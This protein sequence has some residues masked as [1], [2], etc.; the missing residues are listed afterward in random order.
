[1]WY[2]PLIESGRVPDAVLRLGIRRLLA[3]RLESERRGDVEVQC[4]SLLGFV[5]K[6]RASPVAVNTREANSQHYEVP[7][8]FFQAVLGPRLK[9]SS[10]LWSEG[11]RD[12]AA[13]ELAMLE[14]TARRAELADGQRILELGCGWGSLTLWMAERFPGARITAVSNSAP[15][16]EFLEARLAEKKLGNVRVI[17]RDMNDFEPEGT[18]DRVVSVEMFEHMKNY[19]E[20][21]ARIARWL[22][23]SGRLFVHIFTHREFA[24]PFEAD[25]EDDWM[26]REFFTGGNMPSDDLLLYFQRDLSIVRH[27]RVNGTHYAR[28]AESWLSNLDQRRG[29][30]RAIF[31]RVYGEARAEAWIE[32]WRIFFMA[33]AELWGYRGGQEWMVSHYLFAP[34]APAGGAR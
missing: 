1:M 23:P 34:R 8:E 28:T 33:C 24:Y 19:E 10:G 31:E 12:L 15:Q 20:L 30:V 3:E 32:K 7:P 22:E 29:E 27:W 6:L 21:L 16:R 5:E 11:V 2:Q 14:L 9:Y 26:A 13:A 18:F 25:G 17:T 4:E